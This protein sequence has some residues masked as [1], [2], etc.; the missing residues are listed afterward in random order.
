VTGV[1][2]FAWFIWRAG[3]YEPLEEPR[4]E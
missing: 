3:R 4:T 2:G 1:A